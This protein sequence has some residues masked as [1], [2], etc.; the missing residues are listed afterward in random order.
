MKRGN[1][2]INGI[3]NGRDGI[4]RKNV[5]VT[6][7]HLHAQVTPSWAEAMV[8]NAASY[9]RSKNRANNA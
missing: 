6:Y 3:I 2:I 1:G 8:R 7:C 4:C 5:L 9:G